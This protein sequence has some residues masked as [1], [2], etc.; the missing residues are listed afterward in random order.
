MNFSEIM[1]TY[2]GRSIE[3]FQQGNM[4]AGKLLGVTPGTMQVEVVR[5]IYSPV[6]GEVT[7]VD[8]SIDFVRI[9]P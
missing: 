7:I 4:L 3:C 6:S 2:V 9:L 1:E 5:N 8:T